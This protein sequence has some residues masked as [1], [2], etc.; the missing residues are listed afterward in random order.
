MKTETSLPATVVFGSNGFI[1]R[2]L[3]LKLSENNPKIIGVARSAM[4]GMLALDLLKPDI[5]PLELKSRGASYAI[6]AAAVSKIGECEA[7]PL[8]TQRLRHWPV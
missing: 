3:F 8:S 5:R 6:I 2:N 1:G 4:N 7:D